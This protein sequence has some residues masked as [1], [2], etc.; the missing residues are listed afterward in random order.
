VADAPAPPPDPMNNAWTSLRI[1]RRSAHWCRVSFDHP[2]ANAITP[3]TLTELTEL[4]QLIE[5][6]PD[7]EVV[8]FDSAVP[9]AF[10]GD[11]DGAIP[12]EWAALVARIARLRAHTIAAV[13][14]RAEGAGALLVLAC[15]R[16]FVARGDAVLGPFPAATEAAGTRPAPQDLH[17]TL[18]AADRLDAAVE[19][20][21]RRQ[22]GQLS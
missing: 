6:D 15:D 3:A 1:D 4:T 21:A 2:P 13:R 22:L 14:G 16:C 5:Q 18:V 7:L 17:L 12:C 19:A 11:L 8:V 9:G 20:A 10:L